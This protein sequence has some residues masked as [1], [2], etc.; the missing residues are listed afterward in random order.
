MN[1]PLKPSIPKRKNSL[2]KQWDKTTKVVNVKQKIHSNVSDKYTEL[3]IATFTKWVNIQLRTIEEVIDESAYFSPTTTTFPFN[4]AKKKI[5]EINAIDKDFQDGKKLIELLELFYENDTEELP[6]PERGNSRVHY[7]QNVNKVLEFLQKKLDDNGLTALKAI[8]PVDIV[9]GNVKLTLGLI[10]LMISKFHQMISN[11]F[12]VTEEELNQ[13]EERF[14]RSEIVTHIEDKNGN[15]IEISPKSFINTTF[16]EFQSKFR[17][18][19]IESSS[20]DNNSILNSPTILEEEPE[21]LIYEDKSIENQSTENESTECKLTK[22]QSSDNQLTKNKSTENNTIKPTLRNNSV[23]NRILSNSSNRLSLPPNYNDSNGEGKRNFNPNSPARF[24]TLHFIGMN[25]GIILAA[26]IHHLNMEWIDDFDLLINDKEG[27]SENDKEIRIK[28]RLTM[29]FNIINDRLNITQSKALTSMLIEKDYSDKERLKRTGL[30][31]SVYIS[32]IF[33]SITNVMNKRKEIR[34]QSKLILL[35]ENEETTEFK[36]TEETS[37]SKIEDSTKLRGCLSSFKNSNSTPPSKRNSMATSNLPPLPPWTPKVSLISAVWDWTLTSKSRQNNWDITNINEW[38]NNENKPDDDGP[39]QLLANTHQPA[40]HS[41]QFCQHATGMLEEIIQEAI[42]KKFIVYGLSEHC[43]RYRI[44]DLYPEESHLQPLDLSKTFEEFVKEARRLQEKYKSQI[45]LLVGLESE[46]I[47]SS[48]TSEALDLIE[49]YSLDYVVGSVHH[50]HETP[51]DFDLEMFEIALSKSSSNKQR[52]E[53][54]P[55][56]NLFAEYFDSQYQ[57]LQNIKPIIVGH[58]DVIRIYRPNFI[59]SDLIWKKVERNID[60][61]VNYGGLFEIN[62]AGFKVGLPDAY[63]QRDIL[64]LILK[65]G[66]KCTISDDSHGVLRVAMH[67]DRLYNYLK[68]MNINVLYYL[69]YNIEDNIEHKKVIVKE[70]KNV[71][72]HPFWDQFNSS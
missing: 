3:Q 25:D 14:K 60:Y 52:I 9:D 8:G 33:L 7:I 4:K 12:E 41:G 42:K 34:R 72:D 11:V 19:F 39:L 18:H 37:S 47:T 21:E 56:E 24:R 10:W 55:E 59:F 5:P 32:E 30:A 50:V 40:L 64:Q 28:E 45:T 68:E 16:E 66:G 71:L 31:W 54:N 63:P 22:E 35:N 26:L 62:S 49:K 2:K 23:R 46:T 27:E 36:E 17:S 57:M 1:K 13:V 44:E 69:D 65:K 67:Y 20:S 48:S 70:M 51:I 38:K 43:P 29:C 6:K 58:F 15:K 53:N 61:V